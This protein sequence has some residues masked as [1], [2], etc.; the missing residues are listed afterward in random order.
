MNRDKGS[1]TSSSIW[2]LSTILAVLPG[3]LGAARPRVAKQP[4]LV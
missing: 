3:T 4:R 1:L 2:V